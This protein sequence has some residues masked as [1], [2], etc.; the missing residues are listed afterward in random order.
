MARQKLGDRLF[1]WPPID[2]ALDRSIS[3][4]VWSY[5][6]V[7][8][9]YGVYCGV[10]LFSN[11]LGVGGARQITMLSYGLLASVLDSV[12]AEVFMM[13]TGLLLFFVVGLGGTKRFLNE[14]SLVWRRVRTDESKKFDW[15]H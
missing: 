7:L 6:L 9:G 1:G 8:I 11:L 12:I 4:L 15:Q 2:R 10:V 5:A 13:V 14:L 3:V